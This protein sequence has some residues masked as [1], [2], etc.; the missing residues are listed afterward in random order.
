MTEGLHFHFHALEK[1]MATHSSVL[2][3]RIPGKLSCSVACEIFPQ[4]GSNLGLPHCR[5]ILHPSR[6]LQDAELS[7]LCC[8]AAS[9]GTSKASSL[10]GNMKC[11]MQRVTPVAC[12]C[13]LVTALPSCHRIMT[14]GRS[15]ARSQ[16]ATFFQG[17]EGRNRGLVH[18]S[19]ELQ[20][21]S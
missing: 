4:Q 6:P 5:L 2:A 12:P 11:S 13:P 19:T 3:W 8:T 1:E 17:E 18:H 9:T 14:L 15:S 16:R 10:H 7:S 20:S 21:Q